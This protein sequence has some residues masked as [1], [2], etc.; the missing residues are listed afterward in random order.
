M[1]PIGT[2]DSADALDK[3]R[4]CAFCDHHGGDVI[5][6]GEITG[7]DDDVESAWSCSSTSDLLA[8]SRASA[9]ALV[10]VDGTASSGFEFGTP[11]MD[12]PGA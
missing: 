8:S 7:G 1:P 5:D 9:S 4:W 12:R 2:T 11:F 10:A 6:D 3:D